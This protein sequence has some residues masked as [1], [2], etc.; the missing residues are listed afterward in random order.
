MVGTLLVPPS[1]IL[2][3]SVRP[4]GKSQAMLRGLG[5]QTLCAAPNCYEYNVNRPSY[6]SIAQWS[7][8]WGASSRNKMYRMIHWGV[9]KTLKLLFL[10]FS[11]AWIY[12]MYKYIYFV[13][14]A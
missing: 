8:K 3:F 9:G 13:M 4:S 6:D 12:F 2:G 14:Y 10:N 5:K 7:S 1:H 11:S